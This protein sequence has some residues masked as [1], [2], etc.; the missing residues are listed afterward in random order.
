MTT[1]Q[2]STVLPNPDALRKV[3]DSEFQGLLSLARNELGDAV[4][5]APRTAEGAFVRAW[6]ARGKFQSQDDL[7][8]FLR[9]D[10]KAASARALVRRKQIQES[11][12]AGMVSLKT[13][14]HVAASTAVDP[15]VSWSHIIAAI[16]L[17]P[18]SAMHDKMSAQEFRHETA[19]RLEHAT[20]RSPLI[21]ASVFIVIVIA[22]I[23]NGMYVNR[24]STELAFANAMSS[25]NGKVTASQFG[26]IGKVTLGDGSEVTL[27]PDSKLFVPTDFGNKIR[28]VKLDGTASFTVAPAQGDFRV[29]MR[30][31][32]ITAKGTKFVVSGR[33]GDT[34]VLV[35]V[36][37][38][39]VDVRVGKGDGRTVSANQAVSVDGAGVMSDASADEAAE[40]SSWTTGTLTMVNRPLRDILPQLQ[41]WYKVD[42]GVRDMKLLDRKSTLKAN[43]DSGNVALDQVAK[44][45]G[46]TVIKDA[47]HTVLIDAAAK[48]AP[49]T[50]KK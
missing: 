40:A 32:V 14:E 22:A 27:G 21:A 11:G 26:Q 45:A 36:M 4:S 10:V 43:L 47:G 7:K 3:F 16:H 30:N 37:E 50:K 1:P 49:K 44:G 29:Y 23:F 39:S 20:R 33:M 17:D 46:L 31:A 15:N 5:L 2:T 8:R 9:D 28:P 48:P 25:A 41:R 19:E 6:D 18:Q 12:E 42:A 35:K 24:M 34:A 38:G 13:A